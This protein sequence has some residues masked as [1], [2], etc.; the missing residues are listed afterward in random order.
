ML[1]LGSVAVAEMIEPIGTD[2][3]RETLKLASPLASVVTV[4]DAR[5]V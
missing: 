2:S 4:V 5:Y 1:L 3:P